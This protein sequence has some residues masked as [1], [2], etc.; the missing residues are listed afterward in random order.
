VRLLWELV[1]RSMKH[2]AATWNAPSPGARRRPRVNCISMHACH[3]RSA[4]PL[5]SREQAYKPHRHQS[6]GRNTPSLLRRVGA[7]GL[8]TKIAIIER[9][10]PGGRS[11]MT[12]DGRLQG[13]HGHKIFGS[14]Y[15]INDNYG[16]SLTW[17]LDV[18]IGENYGRVFDVSCM[19]SIFDWR[20]LG[21]INYLL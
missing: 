10:S 17:F 14:M 11:K 16:Y 3:S 9:A 21:V 13:K 4:P 19:M 18:L 20:E 5:E 7:H 8:A 12:G 1:S 15:L 6:I 2:T